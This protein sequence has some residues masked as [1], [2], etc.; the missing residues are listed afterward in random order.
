[1]THL[2]DLSLHVL[3]K[4]CFLFIYRDI[5]L[6]D[7]P[8]SAVDAHVGAHIFNRCILQALKHKT[9]ILVTHQ[10]QVQYFIYSHFSYN[11]IVAFLENTALWKNGVVET[12]GSVGIKVLGV[13]SLASLSQM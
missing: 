6:L 9:V 8:L 11:V 3:V 10:G 5:Y 2:L 4:C 12:I 1:M 7:D 13:E